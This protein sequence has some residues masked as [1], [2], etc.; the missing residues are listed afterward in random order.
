M[1]ERRS[2]RSA[3]APEMIDRGRDGQKWRVIEPPD[4]KVQTDLAQGV[5]AVP[6]DDSDASAWVRRH[7]M[8][9]LVWSPDAVP[10]DPFVQAFE[11]ARLNL[12]LKR[13]GLPTL[14]GREPGVTEATVKTAAITDK[15]SAALT[16]VAVAATSDEAEAAKALGAIDPKIAQAANDALRR[17]RRNPTWPGVQEA[18]EYLRK[19]ITM[20][21][22]AT[23]PAP[24]AGSA[25][26]GKPALKM[27][28]MPTPPTPAAPKK[29][30]GDQ[31]RDAEDKATQWLKKAMEDYGISEDA[32]VAVS[33]FVPKEGLLPSP[34]TPIYSG[35]VTWTPMRHVRTKLPLRL[36]RKVGRGK[37][38]PADSGA[39]PRRMERWATDMAVFATRGRQR[40]GTVL[41]DGSGSM[42]LSAEAITML[43][44]QVP[45]ATIA[46]YSGRNGEGYLWILAARGRR[47]SS[48]P[49]HPVGN[50]VDGPAL[51]WLARQKAPRLWVSDGEV[52]GYDDRHTPQL[53]TEAKS[54][55]RVFGIKR[56][57]TLVDTIRYMSGSR[58][59]VHKQ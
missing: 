33:D 22:T 1:A 47:V 14:T 58:T 18:A 53:K 48:I 56:I 10:A 8:A 40:S 54:I 42:C 41:I 59:V 45:A 24:G 5:M 29:P 23:R 25:G 21:K 26:T 2:Q 49:S 31:D 13:I 16:R 32:P 4:G 36:P 55:C 51:R 20:A 35:D 43:V 37:W 12:N 39:H 17:L 57:E 44:T 11:E 38:R 30:K 15:G 27:P 3:P 52:T 9:R 19:F 6:M 7:E 46:M 50:C 28:P 34:L